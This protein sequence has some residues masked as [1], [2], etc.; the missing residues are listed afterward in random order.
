[1][2]ES[3]AQATPGLQAKPLEKFKLDCLSAHNQS[4]IYKQLFTYAKLADQIK[5]RQ[6]DL[7]R[8]PVQGSWELRQTDF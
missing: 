5:P 4:G 3:A 2:A 7:L 1:V 8:R 6:R